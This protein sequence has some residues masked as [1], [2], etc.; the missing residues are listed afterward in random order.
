MNWG[1]IRKRSL[2]LMLSAALLGTTFMSLAAM[3][4]RANAEPES[5]SYDFEDGT[6]QGWYGRGGSEVLTAAALAA[7]SGVYGLQVEGRTQGWN[8][9]QADITSMMKE[10]Q[11]YALSAWLRLPAGTPDASVSMTIQR[12]T[13]GTDHYENVTSGPVQAGGWVRLKGEY[14][15]PAASEKVTIYFESPDHLTLAFYIDDIRIERLPDSPPAAIQEDIPSLKDVFEDDFMLGS[16]FLVSEIADPNGPDAKLLKKHF[17]SLTAGN[18]LKWDATEPQ[19]GTFDFTR[20][21]QAFRFAVDHGMAFRGHTLVWHSQTPDWVFR[22]ADGNL[23]SKEVLLQRMK[24]HI[25]TV[26]GRYKGRIYAWDVVNEVIDPS[27]PQ[28]LRNSLW[29]QIAGEEY[30]EKAFEY[31]HAADPSAKLFINDYNTHDPVKRQYLYDLIKRLKE[32]GIPVDGVGHQ[33]HNSIQS[34]SPQQIDATIGTFRDLGIEQQITELDMS[35]YTNDTDS[36]ETFP[37]DLQIRQAYQYKDTFDVFKK[38]KDQITAVIFW[39]KDDGNTWLRTFPTV[40]K[41]WPLLF[42]ENLQ[43]KYAYWALVDP[44]KV[45]VEIGHASAS[46]SA[47]LIN[48]DGRLEEAWAR[49]TSVPVRKNG[50]TKAA[51]TS[52]WDQRHLYVT[53]DVFDTTVNGNDAVEVYIDGNNGKTPAY[54]PDDKKYTFR[55]SGTNPHKH[56]DYK[57]IR[58]E[59]GYRTEA[60]IPIENGVL[61]QE[62]GFD[63][64][65]ADRSGKDVLMSSWNDTTGSQD[66]DTSKF[67]VLKLDEGPRY[68]SAKQGTP[69]IDGTIDAAWNGMDPIRT[70][71]YVIGSAGSM[72]KVRTLWDHERLYILAEVKDTL[73]SKQSGNAY[74]QD[75]IEIFVDT[76][77]AKTDFFEPDDGQY[78]INFDNERSVNP[79]SLSGN[80]ISAAK[81]TEDGYVVEASIAWT[82]VP[83]KANELIGFDIQVNNDEDGDGDRDSVSIWND[84]SGQSYQNTSGYGLLKLGER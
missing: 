45:P 58:T 74:E 33:M 9:P 20:A 36:W 67:G 26:V 15:L 31:A 48:I 65:I 18:E 81:R 60:S 55:R 39:G 4:N 75:S 46:T 44:G 13:G 43:A 40:R 38:H 50:E 1:L 35:S 37:V 56:A 2:S 62:L 23:A 34:P 83:P 68:V 14:T 47:G 22:G 59:G 84:T 82:G 73:L 42:D 78:R 72:A 66:T 57:T 32:K 54:E 49:G 12:T 61:G 3:P 10:G 71:R 19:E 69:V 21:D 28:G 80:L 41:N 24:R 79:A 5:L 77:N 30:I 53:I 64:R 11:P 25:D 29:Y 51:F 7:H 52:L 17:N 27:Q 76:N 70:D 16:A 6:T 8:G 63:I